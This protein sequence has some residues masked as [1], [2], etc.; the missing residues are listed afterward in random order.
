MSGRVY[1]KLFDP[2]RRKDE[3]RAKLEAPDVE[4][5]LRS[6]RADRERVDV[7]STEIDRTVLCGDCCA[8][9]RLSFRGLLTGRRSPVG[10]TPRPPPEISA[11]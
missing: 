8:A 9:L 7:V 10:G 1:A 6:G 4:C 2:T 11:S 3:A 5:D